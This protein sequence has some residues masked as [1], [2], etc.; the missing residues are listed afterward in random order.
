[1]SNL[2]KNWFYV[3]KNES[4]LIIEKNIHVS[5]YLENIENDI[6]INLKENSKLELYAFFY[7]NSPKNIILN[8]NENNSTL[9][10]KAIY[11]D[12]GVD[13]SS[14]IISNISSNN[15]ISKIKIYSIIK[16]E[17]IEINSSIKVDKIS[18][19][20]NANL[21]LENIF[22]WEKWSIISNPNL[23]IDNFDVKVN[24]SSKTSRIDENRLFY[25][26]SRWLDQE[27]SINTILDSYFRNNFACIEMYDKKLFEDIY[28]KY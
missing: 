7:K 5:L 9:K 18:K 6:I 26:K 15:S 20:T 13:L 11:L 2:N 4:S 3:L 21:D 24:H 17:K 16:N 1:M 28:K 25:L 27:N 22:I 10:F 8:Q 19:N 23:F 12:K 14:N